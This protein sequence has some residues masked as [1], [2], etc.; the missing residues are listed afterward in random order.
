M[1]ISELAAALGVRPSAL[2]YWDAE[3]LV[4]PRRATAGGARQYSPADVRDA[5]FGQNSQPAV[6]VVART[7]PATLDSWA[8][9]LQLADLSKVY[10]AEQ[11]GENLSVIQL[12]APGDPQHGV[13]HGEVH[14]LLRVI[15]GRRIE[16]VQVA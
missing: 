4:V 3:G 15:A 8:A 16:A 6:T 12:D 14:H 5:R 2:R 9:G 11:V 1:S 10:P 13:L 7:D